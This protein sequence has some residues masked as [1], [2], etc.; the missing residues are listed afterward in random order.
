MPERRFRLRRD[1]RWPTAAALVGFMLLARPAL[2][3][4]FNVFAY[5][6]GN[7]I[8]GEAYVRSG[9]PVQGVAVTALDPSGKELAATTTDHEGRFSLPLTARCD[10]RLVVDAGE[11]HVAEYTVRAD[12]LP[13]GMPDHAAV[14]APATGPSSA[15]PTAAKPPA[16]EPAGTPQPETGEEDLSNL[17]PPDESLERQIDAVD[18]QVK[19]LRRDLYEYRNQRQWQ[20]VLGALGYIL[21]IMGLAFYFLGVR[22]KEKGREGRS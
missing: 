16:A 5:V 21:G 14:P 15:G 9:D 19:A 17:G 8:V 12:E 13:A 6:Q 20:D 1:L 11:G 4:K 18:R 7:S 22:R 10:Y 3:H 2:A